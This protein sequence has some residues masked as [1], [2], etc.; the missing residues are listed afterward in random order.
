MQAVE[1]AV[2]VGVI[3]GVQS[4]SANAKAT[5]HSVGVGVGKFISAGVAVTSSRMMGVGS[6]NC[7]GVAVSPKTA[8]VEVMSSRT[9]GV[10]GT[11]ISTT[12]PVNVCVRVAVGVSVQYRFNPVVGLKPEHWVGVIEGAGVSVQGI[13]RPALSWTMQTVGV[14]GGA[15]RGAPAEG[16]H[17]AGW[18]WGGRGSAIY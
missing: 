4:T 12:V 11:S 1:L 2:G 6:I 3:V 16:L 18:C 17:C 14:A 7:A 13:G 10:A 9:I 5:K 15:G 8:G